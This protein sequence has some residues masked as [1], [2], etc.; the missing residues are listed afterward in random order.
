MRDKNLV[1]VTAI[2]DGP[3]CIS[4]DDGHRVHDEIAARLR[5]KQHVVVSFDGVGTIISA[6]LNAAIG[7]LYGEFDESDIRE[8]LEVVD[9]S[10][11]DLG[12]LKRVVDNAKSYFENRNNVDSAWHDEVGDEE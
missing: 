2:V 6:F 3:L 9:M 1:N 12:L 5:Q 7:Q 4:A 8:F 10:Q 11:E